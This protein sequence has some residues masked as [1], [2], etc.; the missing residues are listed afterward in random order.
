MKNLFLDIETLPAPEEEMDK[1]K[2][3]YEKLKSRREK[4]LGAEAIPGD[5]DK[6]SFVQFHANTCFDG[7]F[8]RI[9]CIG[10][11]E[12]DKPT[13]VICHPDDEKKTVEEFWTLA[14][15]AE[16]LVGHNLIE[17]DL[18]FIWQR[19]VKFGIN[20]SWSEM[21]LVRNHTSRIFDTA[22][23]WT[24]GVSMKDPG[25]E[26]LALALGMPSP[27]DGIDGASVWEYYKN[28]KID[29]ICEYC[30]RD[31]ET[32]REIWKRMTFRK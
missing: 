8:G 24:K 11:A 3:L 17:F 31:V 29:Q 30:Q 14:R 21:S 32:T 16:I 20:P 25:L 18:R 28:G 12:D 9:L 6:Y 7:A 22:K 13:E 4:R 2:Y 10:Y 5:N 15:E 27:K 1:L 26:H 23:E 19:S